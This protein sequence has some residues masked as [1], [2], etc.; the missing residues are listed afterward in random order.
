SIW[1]G[2]YRLQPGTSLSI[3]QQGVPCI[4]RWH[5]GPFP[6]LKLRSDEEYYECFRELFDQALKA[7]LRSSTPVFVQLSG[8]L[9]SSSVVCRAAQLYQKGIV[10]KLVQPISAV[11]PG[12]THDESDYINMVAEKSGVESKRFV[13][14]IYDWDEHLAWAKDAFHLP[15]RPNSNLMESLAA[16]L[17]EYGSLVLLTGEGGDDWLVG[18]FSHFPDLLKEGRF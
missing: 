5:E 8:G 13:P 11:F 6:E 1:K 15:L 12:K 3:K 18:S 9:D 4:R 2:I 14:G 10:D 7:C 16:K 17:P